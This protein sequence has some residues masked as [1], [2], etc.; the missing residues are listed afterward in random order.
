M[1]SAIQQFSSL[2]ST[3]KKN[4]VI[5]TDGVPNANSITYSTADGVSCT[6]NC[7][8]AELQAGAQTQAALAKAGG[9]SISTI[10]YSGDTDTAQDQAIYAAYLATLV[11]GSGTALV[12]PTAAQISA[13][14]SGIC[15]TIP[16]ALVSVR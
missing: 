15:S 5:I 11:T 13:A 7:T 2:T 4:I 3:S 1:Y 9:I 8:D 12:A 14:Y 6:K 10:Y 16:S